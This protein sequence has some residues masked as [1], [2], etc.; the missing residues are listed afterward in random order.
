MLCTIGCTRRPRRI[1]VL[2]QSTTDHAEEVI[3][4][5]GFTLR[6]EAA[7][8]VAGKDGL[9]IGSWNLAAKTRGGIRIKQ[10]VCER[11]QPVGSL[12]RGI[13][14]EEEHAI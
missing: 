6:A 2:S 11:A 9:T 1:A 10:G 5:G 8:V 14:I 3:P 4:P 7:V 13:G 12:R